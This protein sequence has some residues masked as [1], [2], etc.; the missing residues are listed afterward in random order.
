MPYSKTLWTRFKL[1]KGYIVHQRKCFTVTALQALFIIIKLF[2]DYILLFPSENG[3]S[4]R[5]STNAEKK[6]IKSEPEDST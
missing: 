3:T 2:A 1:M 6:T 5:A 4:Q